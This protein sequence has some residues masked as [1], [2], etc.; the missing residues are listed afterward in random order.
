MP[1]TPLNRISAFGTGVATGIAA[2]VLFRMLVTAIIG[3]TTE[4]FSSQTIALIVILLLPPLVSFMFLRIT[5]GSVSEDF[6]HG[7]QV[8][9]LIWLA[10]ILAAI[11]G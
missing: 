4:F 2:Q 9:S 10:L 8:G 1:P 6:F 3:P 5:P 11:F 7:F